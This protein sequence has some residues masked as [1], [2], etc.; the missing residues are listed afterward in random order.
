MGKIGRMYPLGLHN[1]LSWM[2]AGKRFDCG[3]MVGQTEVVGHCLV[4]LERIL[5][6]GCQEDSGIGSACVDSGEE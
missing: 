1:T 3:G 5:L 2:G 4:R 6:F